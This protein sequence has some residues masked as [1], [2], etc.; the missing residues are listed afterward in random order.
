M[1]ADRLQRERA[2]ADLADRQHG[3]IAHWQ[4]MALGLGRGAIRRRLEN[5]RLQ[6]VYPGVYAVGRGRLTIR[7]HWMAAVLACGED[8]L[9]SNGSGAAL[10]D[11]LP[12]KGMRVHV[13][14]PRRGV[15]EPRGLT[16][17]TTLHLPPSE[18]TIR[19]NVPVTSVAR[20]LLDLAES[21]PERLPRAWNN[22]ARRRLLDL[23][24]VAATCE[25]GRG[26][27]GLK[28]LLP[29]LED[30][31]RVIPDTRRELE[32][33]F[34][35]LCRAFDLPPP[36]CN[37][38]VEGYLVDAFWPKQ[39]VVVELDSWEFHHDRGAFERDRERDGTLQAAGYRVVLITWRRLTED[40]AAVARLI[41]TLLAA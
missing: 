30:R 29:L 26:R 17:H 34:F 35:D 28:H 14:V 20:T 19:D 3:V 5:F 15:R 27:R 12:V 40:T 9:L 36:A 25:N 18:R 32:A 16:V 21:D 22:A 38:L 13:T 33:R 4:L 11:L 8:A 31:T 37:V 24:A 7:G 2:I 41:R 6:R 10:W 39:R 23:R 1:D